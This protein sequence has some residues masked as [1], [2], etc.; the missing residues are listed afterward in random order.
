MAAMLRELKVK[1]LE[2]GDLTIDVMPTNTITELKARLHQ[3]KRC[4]DPVERQILQAKV[5]AN[6]GLLLDDDQTLESAGL[7]NE[8]LEVTVIY[9]RN[10]VEAAT[11]EAIH[12]EGFLQ[13]NIPSSLTEIPAEAFED[14]HQVVTVAIPESVTVIGE[15]AFA[16]CKYLASITIPQSLTAIG[17]FA[18]ADC[19][20]LENI[21]I[22]PSVTTIGRGAF[23][24]C[25][26]LASITIAESV[27]SIG[28]IAFRNCGS[29]ASITVPD[30]V[31]AIGS[32]AFARCIS[33]A[34]ITIPVSVTS[35]GS[36]A[37]AGC[38]SLASIAIPESV[39]AIGDRAFLKCSSLASITIPESVT[40]IGVNAFA[41]CS[42][43]ES[44]TIPESLRDDGGR[45]FDDNLQAMI[46]HVWL[47]LFVA[48]VGTLLF[49]FESA[50]MGLCAVSV[51]NFLSSRTRGA[52]R[53]K[54]RNR[55]SWN[56]KR[57]PR[58][59]PATQRDWFWGKLWEEIFGPLRPPKQFA[60]E[61]IPSL[62]LTKHLK[63]DGWKT[64]F[65]LGRPIFRGELLVLGRVV[66]G[67][68]TAF[69]SKIW[70][71]C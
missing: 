49:K 55:K 27:T 52:S 12:A 2:G 40:T 22:P 58:N 26:S 4:E 3:E 59:H 68:H 47:W 7:L 29:L 5:L 46:Q 71:N 13:V 19:K 21:T 50:S 39:T 15:A 8:E 70:S 30:S 38:D 37:F 61:K 36:Y 31:T 44:I 62:K 69:V 35:I 54:P 57:D 6:G 9:S 1:T 14:Y 25:N 42:S 43:L 34:S 48:S 60:P 32:Y 45:A 33:L 65:L 41:S 64:T 23:E 51:I 17:E 28:D 63:M 24:D 20:S 56:G 11:K 10:E 18:F 16:G 67:R 53:K 66:M